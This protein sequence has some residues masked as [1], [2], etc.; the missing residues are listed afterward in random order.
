MKLNEFTGDFIQDKENHKRWCGLNDRTEYMKEYRL[1]N[2]EKFKE[3]G[4]ENKEKLK[5][6]KKKWRENLS[7]EKTL[8]IK[9]RER[10]LYHLKNRKLLKNTIT[11]NEKNL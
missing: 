3:W 10:E 11:K 4:D 5:D 1:S 8:E 9:N 7:D 6:S 2:P